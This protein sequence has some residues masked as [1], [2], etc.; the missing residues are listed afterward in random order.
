RNGFRYL[1]AVTRRLTRERLGE[2]DLRYLSRLPLTQMLTLDDTRFL[3]VH[4]TPRAPLDENAPPDAELWQLRLHDVEAG[5]VC[6]GDTHQPYVLEVG[7][8]LVINP[9]SIGQPRDDDARASY[10]VIEDYKVELKRHEYPVDDTLRVIQ[11]SG[12]PDEARE[13]LS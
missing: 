10:A 12:L 2:E 6:V 3:L 9:G 7:D 4:A 5:V 13:T 8:K 11:E 1:T